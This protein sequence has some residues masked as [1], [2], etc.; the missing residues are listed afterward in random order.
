MK[1]TLL[2]SDPLFPD[3]GLFPDDGLD[4]PF[5]ELDSFDACMT[6]EPAA[7]QV[8]EPPVD[9]PAPEV[10]RADILVVDASTEP[11]PTDTED[12][13]LVDPGLVDTGLVEADPIE[14]DPIETMAVIDLREGDQLGESLE[15]FTL[16]EFSP[17]DEMGVLFDDS[18]DPALE[19]DVLG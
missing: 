15:D 7:A 17:D 13:G 1:A 5:G 18:T 16:D 14:A 8:D 3:L 4:D 19:F 6:D 10:P 11:E 2:D 12:P 9:I